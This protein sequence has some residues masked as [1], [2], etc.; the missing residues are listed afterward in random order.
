[1]V[2]LLVRIKNGSSQLLCLAGGRRCRYG[3]LFISLLL[4]CNA[5]RCSMLSRIVLGFCDAIFGLKSRHVDIEKNV[6]VCLC[7]F[8]KLT[9]AFLLK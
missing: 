2:A 8:I 1:M 9:V 5:C 7:L 4:P 3:V 6:G